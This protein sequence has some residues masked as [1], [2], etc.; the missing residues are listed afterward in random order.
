MFISTLTPGAPLSLFMIA[1]VEIT[2]T[3]VAVNPPCSVPPRLVCSSSTRIS[4]TTLP[5]VAAKTST[6]GN[7]AICDRETMRTDRLQAGKTVAVNV[8][9]VYLPFAGL[10]R[11]LYCRPL[12][13]LFVLSYLKT[14]T[15]YF[16]TRKVTNVKLMFTSCRKLFRSTNCPAETKC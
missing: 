13:S 2:S 11:N 14:T 6:W 1:M 4:H 12:L 7:T 16:T 8:A 9:C 10:C 15:P 5:G 3:R